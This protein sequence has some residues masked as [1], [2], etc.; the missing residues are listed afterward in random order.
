MG[1]NPSVASVSWFFRA[2]GQNRQV[3]VASRQSVSIETLNP[4]VMRP[5]SSVSHV[6]SVRRILDLDQS[7]LSARPMIRTLSLKILDLFPCGGRHN[8]SNL[9]QLRI[10]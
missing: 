8:L 5:R 3:S 10:L 4:A 7:K 6:R 1:K 2:Y 9:S